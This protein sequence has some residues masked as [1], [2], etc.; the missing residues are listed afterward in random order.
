MGSELDSNVSDP[1][2][3]KDVL[4]SQVSTRPFYSTEFKFMKPRALSQ[5][6][7]P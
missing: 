2:N 4:E 3:L 7:L 6:I 5:A 1:P